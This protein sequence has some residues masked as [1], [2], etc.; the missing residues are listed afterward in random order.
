MKQAIF[1]LIDC[2]NFFVSCERLFRPDLEGLP[3]VVLSSNDG[4][5]V[6]R[7]NEA[8]ALGI[9]M[10]A[11]AFK[12]R[13]AF[14]EQGVKQFSGNFELYGDISQR[15]THVLTGITP[16]TEVYSVDESF[17]DLSQLAIDDYQVWGRAARQRLLREV[18]IPVSIGIAASKTLA[19]LASE[20]AKRDD[21][22]SGVL[23]LVQVSQSVREAYLLNTPINDVWG[24][25]R[26]LAA[27]LRAEGIHNALGLSNMSPRL[28]QQLMGVHGRQ[29][30][31]ELNGI[32]CHRLEPFGKIRQT[33]MHGRM[34]GEDT[35]QFEVIEAAIASLAARAAARLRSER[36][37]A[38]GAVLYLSTNHHKPGY[39]RTG[40]FLS[41][42]TP[43]ADTGV[44]TSHLVRAIEPS[45]NPRA[46]YH[47][48]NVLL[49][50]LVSEHTLQADLFDY[51][52]LKSGEASQTRLRAFDAINN[53]YGRQTIRYAAED[54]SQAWQP[55]RQLRGP[56]YTTNWQELPTIN[57]LFAK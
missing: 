23:D 30:V 42:S 53:R 56:R 2:N 10:G 40:R 18:G 4:C 5:V 36:L 34:F 27:R 41:F 31:A 51:I 43:T 26:K 57:S 1:A 6:S 24:V 50:N 28:A 45:F 38:R 55:K 39:Q 3:V 44:I 25:G 14:K 16:R 7:S 48:V 37:L 52:D 21:G 12:Y 8:R 20:H 19:K 47:Q 13:Q 11:P 15:L 33:I 54:L 29:M 9:P 49:Y 35:N 32:C 46:W 17:L 22:A